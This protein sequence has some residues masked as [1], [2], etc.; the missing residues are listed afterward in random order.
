MVAEKKRLFSFL[1]NCILSIAVTPWN[2]ASMSFVRKIGA[3]GFFEKRCSVWRCYE[4]ALDQ[5]SIGKFK[6]RNQQVA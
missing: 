1:E 6:L 5:R 3:L 2:P 4:R